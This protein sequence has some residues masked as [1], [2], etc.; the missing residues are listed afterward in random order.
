MFSLRIM[1]NVRQLL[2][3]MIGVTVHLIR[4]KHLDNL[5]NW[6]SIKS[7]A[8]VL[9]ILLAGAVEAGGI[10]DNLSNLPH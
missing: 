10:E 7:N 9:H 5:D 1:T 3:C 6:M 8:R 4:N 2:C